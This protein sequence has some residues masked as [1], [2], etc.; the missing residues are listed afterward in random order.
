M[1]RRSSRDRVRLWLS[2]CLALAL[3]AAACGND[4]GGGG[5]G[6]PTGPTPPTTLPPIVPG[7]AGFDVSSTD[8]E[9]T[10]RT[11]AWGFGGPRVRAA[12][13]IARDGDGWIIRP[14]TGARGDFVVRLTATRVSDREATINGTANGRMVDIFSL[15]QFPNPSQAVVTG[16]AGAQDA[17]LTANYVAPLNGMFGQIVGSI[18]YTDNQGGV[19][20]CTSGTFVIVWA[21]S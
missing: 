7:T 1:L 16:T 19:M 18:V 5:P 3:G 11:P 8:G 21:P 4:N 14:V 20:T 17:V 12:G 9:C 10:A 15:L 2:L 13:D 6:L